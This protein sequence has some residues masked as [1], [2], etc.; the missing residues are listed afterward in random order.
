MVVHDSPLLARGVGIDAVRP[1]AVADRTSEVDLSAF[2]DSHRK[3][4]SVTGG[5]LANMAEAKR[6]TCS[7]SELSLNWARAPAEHRPEGCRR[8][9]EVH[10]RDE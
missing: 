1:W 7:A 5:I 9:G 10:Q 6:I 8:I 3:G 4:Y 2:G